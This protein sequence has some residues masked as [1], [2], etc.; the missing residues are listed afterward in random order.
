[1]KRAKR[2]E[3]IQRLLDFKVIQKRIVLITKMKIE[4]GEVSTSREG[5]A[6]AVGEFYRKITTTKN[7]EKLNKKTNRM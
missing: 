7:T 1:M 6:N 4:K 3:E 2:Q 5:I